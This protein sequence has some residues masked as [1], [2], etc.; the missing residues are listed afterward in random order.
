MGVSF[1][2][3][4]EPSHLADLQTGVTAPI[5]AACRAARLD[6][7]LRERRLTGYFAGRAVVTLRWP[8]GLATLD[9]DHKYVDPGGLPGHTRSSSGDD[10]S[11]RITP[12][13]VARFPAE[14]ARL[15]ANAGRYAHHDERCEQQ[16][17]R[18][19]AGNGAFVAI[20]RQVGIPGTRSIVD[21]VGV[22]DGA[23]PS[24]VIVELK[25]DLDNS[26]E[27]TP[28]LVSRYL[29]YFSP[30]GRGLRDDVARSL[31]TVAEQLTALG[32]PTPP[33][34]AI[35]A[36]MPVLGLV[37][38]VRH[39]PR[40]QLLGR[41]KVSADALA[42]PIWLWIPEKEDD[43]AIPSQDRWTRMGSGQG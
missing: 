28:A 31:T 42:H 6:V 30:G 27:E 24:L 3:G 18:E 15:M 20:D 9:V 33:P 36:G 5:L 35:G 11:V 19:N 22:V 14:L 8:Q 32:F 26:I 21:V 2:R 25:R 12:E 39:N 43:L 23:R 4:L 40:S 37:V 41:A 1:N 29:S 34:A 10:V 7:R 38:L 17:L 16:F 13:L